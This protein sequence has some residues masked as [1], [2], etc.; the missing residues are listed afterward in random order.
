LLSVYWPKRIEFTQMS[1][2]MVSSASGFASLLI[3][4]PVAVINAVVIFA[5]VY[6]HLS[7]LP[8]VASLVGLAVSLKIYSWLVSWAVRHAEEHLEEIASQLG[9]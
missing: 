8:L 3:I 9:A 2:R 1:S 5:T 4:L 7:W 6:L